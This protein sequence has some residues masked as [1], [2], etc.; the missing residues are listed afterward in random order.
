MTPCRK[1]PCRIYD[2]GAPV[3]LRAR[4][5][6]DAIRGL[7]DA[8]ALRPSSNVS[9]AQRAKRVPVR[10]AILLVALLRRA[11]CGRATAPGRRDRS[12]ARP[13]CERTDRA[14]R[15]RLID[16]EDQGRRRDARRRQRAPRG[17]SRPA[18]QSPTPNAARTGR[19]AGGHDTDGDCRHQH[20]EHRA[21]EDREPRRRAL[22]SS[23]SMRT[24]RPTRPPAERTRSTRL[25][26]LVGRTTST[27]RASAPPGSSR[28]ISMRRSASR[29]E[30]CRSAP[31]T[32]AS[33]GQTCR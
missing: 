5:A 18:R 3:P 16:A 33:T 14:H 25:Y 26:A 27:R 22:C 28:P 30:D 10:L 31:T 13:T 32:L 24:D 7:R 9:S 4:A 1:D 23:G 17:R 15:P 6:R 29:T 21:R 12:G 20:R 8:S 11:R 2:P 19:R